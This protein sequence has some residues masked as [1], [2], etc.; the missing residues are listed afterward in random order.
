MAEGGLAGGATAPSG[1]H[2]H[3]TRGALR[4]LG[5]CDGD[6]VRGG[7]VRSLDLC[8]GGTCPGDRLGRGG[9]PH[10]N[11]PGLAG[12]AAHPGSPDTSFCGDWMPDGV[13]PCVVVFR[14]VCD[15]FRR[16]VMFDGEEFP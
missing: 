10:A 15:H 14:R 12:T 13:R 16:L 4:A 1:W 6:A 5:R 3:V 8:G 9:V 11:L 7:S 2:R